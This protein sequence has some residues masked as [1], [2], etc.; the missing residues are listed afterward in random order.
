MGVRNTSKQWGWPAKAL[1]W[2]MAILIIGLAL[3]GTFMANFTD[4]MLL[5]FELTQIHK[6]FG[7]VAFSLAALR[8]IWRWINPSPV[9]PVYHSKLEM[10]AAYITHYGLYVLM[11]VMP[12]SGWLMASASV[13]NDADAYPMQVKNMVFGLFE[14]PD[15]IAP[16]DEKLETIFHMIHAYSSYLLATLL[17]LH[18]AGALKHHIVNKDTIL[19]RMVP[20]WRF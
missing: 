16:S 17:V 15:P 14:L 10:V 20:F 11:F 7:F 5:Q 2:I 6:S 19:K 4:N 13:L 12:L 9:A 3:V 18:I 8:M 1:H